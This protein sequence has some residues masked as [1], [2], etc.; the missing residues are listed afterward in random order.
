MLKISRLVGLIAA[1]GVIS[2]WGI[3]GL[4]NPYGYQGLTSS[5][6]V[7]VALMIGLAIVGLFAALTENPYLMLAVFGLS[8]V[9]VGIYLLGTPGIFRWIGGF[10]LLFLLSALLNIMARRENKIQMNL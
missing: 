2:L 7:V 8:F 3:F 1:V 9:P 6:Y 10:D 5:V 4:L